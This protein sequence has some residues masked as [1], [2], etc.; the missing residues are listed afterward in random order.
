MEA[1]GPSLQLA[2]CFS[3]ES[4]ARYLKI[5]LLGILKEMAGWQVT[6][7][8]LFS[9]EAVIR[10]LVRGGFPE[11]KNLLSLKM[12]GAERNLNGQA[13]LNVPTVLPWAHTLSHSPITFDSS[14]N[15]VQKC[16]GL[17]ISL[18][19]FIMKVFVS[20]KTCIKL[21][22]FPLVNLSFASSI[23]GTPAREPR[24]VVGKIISSFPRR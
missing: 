7:T 8:F 5:R 2:S 18:G 12:D 24:Q 15:P 11:E 1:G 22:C 13:V 10:T 16:K 20:R 23:Y 3:V 4:S 9:P 17:R 19:H 14:S 21:V 6:L